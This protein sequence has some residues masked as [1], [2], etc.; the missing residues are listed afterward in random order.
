MCLLSVH[1]ASGALPRSRRLGGGEVSAAALKL[2][3]RMTE[4]REEVQVCK[5]EGERR[6][7]Q[8]RE[9]RRKSGR[10]GEWESGR[11]RD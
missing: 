3:P 4:M 2:M 7:V 1:R 8:G 6:R 9:W 5:R 11:V 10:V